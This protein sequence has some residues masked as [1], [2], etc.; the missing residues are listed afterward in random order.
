MVKNHQTCRVQQ[1]TNLSAFRLGRTHFDLTVIL[2]NHLDSMGR[3]IRLILPSPFTSNKKISTHPNVQYRI[4][5]FLKNLT[6]NIFGGLYFLERVEPYRAP[7][8][9]KM[10]LMLKYFISG[11][12]QIALV[13]AQYFKLHKTKGPWCLQLSPKEL[14]SKPKFLYNN[15]FLAKSHYF[16]LFFMILL[17]V[18]WNLMWTILKLWLLCSISCISNLLS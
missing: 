7:L 9:A 18:L 17:K 12:C 13:L 16:H 4:Q 5:N 6:W 10:P 11:S 3:S 15:L 1:R 2:N 8:R 14:F